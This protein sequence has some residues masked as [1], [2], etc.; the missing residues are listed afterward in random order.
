[1]GKESTATPTDGSAGDGGRQGEPKSE[2]TLKV[3]DRPARAG[4]D[5]GLADADY[6]AAL[7]TATPS[8]R[9]QFFGNPIRAIGKALPPSKYWYYEE[10]SSM[11]LAWFWYQ[12]PRD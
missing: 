1:M 12:H 9:A 5:R 10:G 4:R 6:L 2:A 7:L 11:W 8:R 3:E